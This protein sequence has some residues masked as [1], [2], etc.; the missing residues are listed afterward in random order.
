MLYANAKGNV[1][2]YVPTR[3]PFDEVSVSTGAGYTTV[4]IGAGTPLLFSSYVAALCSAVATQTGYSVSFSWITSS[5]ERRVQISSSSAI[6]LMFTQSQKELLG[7]ASA[8][9]ALDT[10][11]VAENPANG[12]IDCNGIR[13]TGPEPNTRLEVFRY[14]HGRFFCAPYGKGTVYTI[15]GLTD[16]TEAERWLSGVCAVGKLRLSQGDN[17]ALSP[18]Y[19]EGYLDGHPLSVDVQFLDARERIAEVTLKFVVSGESDPST[20]TD[21]W[22]W[23]AE[24]YGLAYYARIQGIPFLFSD[25]A[26][27]WTTT[28]YTYHTGLVLDGS[29]RVGAEV[30]RK[31]GV[32]KSISLDFGILDPTN[33]TGLFKKPTQWFSL[34]ADFTTDDDDATVNEDCSGLS[35]PTKLHMGV[36]CFEVQSVSGTDTLVDLSTK[37]DVWGPSYDYR[38]TAVTMF[39]TLTDTPRVWAG[40]TIELWATLIDPL[41]RP[42]DS[43]PYSDHSRMVFLG[44]LA[45]A[46]A[47]GGEGA[48]NFSAHSLERR[49]TKKVGPEILGTIGFADPNNTDVRN[50]LLWL[51]TSKNFVNVQVR[52][53][54]VGA[55]AMTSLALGEGG[56]PI[57]VG[58]VGSMIA[59]EIED[60][61]V[62]SLSLDV[63]VIPD[64]ARTD[65]GKITI[66]FRIK[67]ADANG[68]A[69]VIVPTDTSPPWIQTGIVQMPV[70][71]NFT[72]PLDAGFIIIDPS[73]QAQ[74]GYHYLP[75]TE[76]PADYGTESF[77]ASGYAVVEG[78]DGKEL[79]HYD[80][81]TAVTGIEGEGSL[82]VLAVNKRGLW[83][84]PLA[85]FSAYGKEVRGVTQLTGSLGALV[86][87]VLESS[88]IG[89]RGTYDTLTIPGQG[90][91]LPDTQVDEASILALGNSVAWQGSLSI[92]LGEPYSVEEIFGGLLASNGLCLAPVTTSD[93]R[94]K[95]GMVRTKP[96][97]EANAVSIIDGHLLGRKPARSREGI[98]GPTVVEIE[99]ADSTLGDN[100]TKRL[101]R[102]IEGILSRGEEK[103]SYKW[104]GVKPN[105]FDTFALAIGKG[106]LT[107]AENTTLVEIDVAPWQAFAVGQA[108][109][110]SVTHHGV[111]DLAS[112]QM[113]LSTTRRG[114]ILSVKR[115]LE[116][117]RVTLALA[118]DGA[119]V[120]GVL[121]PGVPITGTSG[122]LGL[123]VAA[124]DEA[125]F[126]AGEY[127]RVYIP[128]NTGTYW[129]TR[130]IRSLSSGL[131]TCDT[132]PPAWAT[133]ANGACI[134]YLDEGAANARQGAYV[135]VADGSIWS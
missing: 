103:W 104:H 12:F 87:R 96:V 27:G 79:I 61:F 36:E 84:S 43:A 119:F 34:A 131:V 48:W 1:S 116:T 26:L 14:K 107:L 122:P 24:G 7:F 126:V 11:L 94:I 10:V 134:T 80:S 85:D 59:A 9:T 90:Y 89:D 106:L 86:L 108:V 102:S 32:A 49:L 92:L 111:Y 55:A 88:G 46:P 21:F 132:A 68:Y 112:G 64:Y 37:R 120:G 38:A 44:E 2:W 101:F 33:E 40:R 72:D 69:Y 99:S 5:G 100:G 71:D 51:P 23:L 135:H 77:S 110:I 15:T 62:S 54:T 31:S 129:D 81:K 13:W 118:L 41:G 66:L 127:L 65:D 67:S 97:S 47:W 8:T 20:D 30:D 4:T 25:L 78:T 82:Y 93:G 42:V 3:A 76:A 83:S 73:V 56:T 114:R 58:S 28:D 17:H 95:I 109:T 117:G 63:Q 113:G 70:S 39:R 121:C 125:H 60:Q 19:P 53:F 18:T 45:G 35:T 22:G 75:I 115:D 57:T 123:T 16:R 105:Q 133:A 98:T 50:I 124:G 91:A 29:G 52:D 128:G 130:E 6:S 74:P